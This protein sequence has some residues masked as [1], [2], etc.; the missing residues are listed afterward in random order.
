MHYQ[1]LHYFIYFILILFIYLFNL[2]NLANCK[3]TN[4]HLRKREKKKKKKKKQ[5]EWTFQSN[6]QGFLNKLSFLIIKDINKLYLYNNIN[7]N[8]KKIFRNMHK[9]LF[10]L[11][12]SYPGKK[13]A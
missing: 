3:G 1:N 11:K 10:I 4:T 2:Y 13:S 8:T 7:K 9:K 6:K 5:T 12:H